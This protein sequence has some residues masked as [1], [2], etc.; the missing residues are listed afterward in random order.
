MP[1]QNDVGE[2]G[3]SPRNFI[4]STIASDV[5]TGRTR[6]LV[7]RFP[8]EPNG[9][10]HP[11]HAKSIVLNY[12]LAKEFGGRCNLRLDDT[13]PQ[14]RGWSTSTRSK[15]DVQWLGFDWA[16]GLHFASDDFEQLYAWAYHF[17]RI[18]K[19][20]VDVQSAHDIREGR[21]TLTSPGRNSPFRD[22][23]VKE[24]AELFARMRAGEFRNGKRVLRAKTDMASANLNLRAPIIYRILK[25]SHR[26]G[27]AQI[28][29]R[30]ESRGNQAGDA[31]NQ[32][33]A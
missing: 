29:F 24:N 23:S 13:N 32:A 27:S 20:Y 8:P 12:E 31:D 7:T 14:R 1:Q 26:C 17:V 2:A 22:R 33:S 16:Q 9:V 10:L 21:G 11:G 5:E 28:S 19:A 18:G 15:R 25:A 3:A 6:V 30:L 4:H